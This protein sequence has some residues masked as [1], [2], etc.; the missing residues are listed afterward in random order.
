[1]NSALLLDTHIVLW[2]DS[3]DRRLRSST[4]KLLEDFWRDGGTLLVGTITAWEIALLL[5]QAHIEL[6]L[7]PDQWLQ[8]FLDRPGMEMIP[9]S[10]QAAARSYQLAGFEGRDPADRLLVSTAI[11][12]RCPL[13]TYDQRIARFAGRYGK[14]HGFRVVS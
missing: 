2:L 4:R 12:L 6:D 5:D 9:L 13:V 11:E 10:L 1:M 3:G 8:R 7:A 14:Q